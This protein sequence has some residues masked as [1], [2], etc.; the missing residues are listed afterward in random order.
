MKT[1][2]LGEHERPYHRRKFL[3][4]Y[5]F[6][7]SFLGYTVGVAV[8]SVLIFFAAIRYFFWAF[9]NKGIELG[10][11]RGHIFFRFLADERLQMDLILV[12]SGVIVVTAVFLYG[13][14]LSNHVAGPIF[15]LK[16]YLQKYLSGEKTGQLRFRKNDYFQDIALLVMSAINHASTRARPLVRVV[17][18]KSKS[19][20]KLKTKPK[21]KRS[22]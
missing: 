13:L 19:S 9:E 6:Q 21:M 17:S 5:R 16:N 7:R 8:V 10:L 22:A 11:P 4:E 14:I 1:G 3:V 18:K 12:I 15:H 2:N 20:S